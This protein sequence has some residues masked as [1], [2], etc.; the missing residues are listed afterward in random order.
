[1]EGIVVAWMFKRIRGIY[2]TWLIWVGVDIEEDREMWV[3]K[4]VLDNSMDVVL[5]VTEHYSLWRYFVYESGWMNGDSHLTNLVIL[6]S[7]KI[8]SI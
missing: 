8:C 1:M 6:Q 4:S 7:E 5:W 3:S 2:I